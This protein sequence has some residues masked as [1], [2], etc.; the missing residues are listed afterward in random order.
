MMMALML[1]WMRMMT[2]AMKDRSRA[3]MTIDCLPTCMLRSSDI[4]VRITYGTWLDILR[5]AALNG[6][7][8]R[9]DAK[10]VIEKVKA[11]RRG[12]EEP[13]ADGSW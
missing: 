12:E 3:D 2:R 7:A 8:K 9:D 13:Q 10:K 11:D 1:L 4:S 5:H 6:L